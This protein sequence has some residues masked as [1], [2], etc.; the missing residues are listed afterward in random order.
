MDTP[1]LAPAAWVAYARAT[2]QYN[3]GSN[4]P[5]TVRVR[6]AAAVLRRPLRLERR[7]QRKIQAASTTL[8][9]PGRAGPDVV[10]LCTDNYGQAGAHKIL[11][12]TNSRS[13]IS[14]HNN[15][16]LWG[17]GQRPANILIDS[18]NATTPKHFHQYYDYVQKL[19]GHHQQSLLGHAL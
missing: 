2:H 1:V 15:Y 9:H 18:L 14:G 3:A 5:K 13:V 16:Y 17:P 11:S 10:I 6:P 12:A 7:R 4:S 19:L 8:A